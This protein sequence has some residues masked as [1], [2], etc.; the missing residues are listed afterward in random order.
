M[1]Q[2]FIDADIHNIFFGYISKAEIDYLLCC[3]EHKL[4]VFSLLKG[5]NPFAAYAS[6]DISVWINQFTHEKGYNWSHLP[7]DRQFDMYQIHLLMQ[8]NELLK[9]SAI[10]NEALQNGPFRQ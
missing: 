7:M 10:L 2:Y 6:H 9:N 4:N 8:K 3:I 1:L 5:G